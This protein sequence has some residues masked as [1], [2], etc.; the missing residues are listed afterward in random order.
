MWDLPRPGLEPMSPALAGG[1]LTTA[2]PGKPQ[3][4]YFKLQQSRYPNKPAPL[5]LRI[6]QHRRLHHQTEKC[7]SPMTPFSL[8]LQH[9]LYQSWV[10]SMCS[11]KCLLKECV[12]HCEWNGR[13]H[14]LC[15]PS[16]TGCRTFQRF[17]FFFF[18]GTAKLVTTGWKSTGPNA[19]EETPRRIHRS[20]SETVLARGS[21]TQGFQSMLAIFYH[22]LS[23][24]FNCSVIVCKWKTT[25]PRVPREFKMVV[26]M[27]MWNLI[28]NKLVN[29]IKRE[30]DSQIQRTN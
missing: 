24:L 13:T 29:K 7:A 10:Y 30:A 8:L 12:C 2:Q 15:K 26:S 25:F 1:F 18:W 28:H 19:Q 27:Y 5:T 22:I 4:K 17:F 9:Q 14:M 21:C 23:V 11:I 16:D 6:H 3:E 20:R